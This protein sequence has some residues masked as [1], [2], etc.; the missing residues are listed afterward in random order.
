MHQVVTFLGQITA[1][2]KSSSNSRD[3]RRGG[4]WQAARRPPGR[5][6]SPANAAAAA[7]WR[8]PLQRALPPAA[9]GPLGWPPA[10]AARTLPGCERS[11]WK[12]QSLDSSE[13]AR[14]SFASAHSCKVSHKVVQLQAMLGI[15][16]QIEAHLDLWHG[17][18]TAQLGA[19]GQPYRH[20]PLN[21]ITA[22][23]RQSHL[24]QTT[25]LVP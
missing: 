2:C 22:R 10:S 8:P 14:R 11:A 17:M 24:L 13:H 25:T 9:A 15:N 23:C 5:G 3:W 6:A 20:A 12:C 4:A 16:F 18:R 1:S 7:R 21:P 19:S